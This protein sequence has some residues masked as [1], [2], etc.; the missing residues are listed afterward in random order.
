MSFQRVLHASG[1]LRLRCDG[2][3]GSRLLVQPHRRWGS[4]KVPMGEEGT[5]W[6]TAGVSENQDDRLEA[7]Q[8]SYIN[9]ALEHKATQEVWIP[10]HIWP[11]A[12]PS[13]SMDFVTA[14]SHLRGS[15]YGQLSLAPQPCGAKGQRMLRIVLR[16]ASPGSTNVGANALHNDEHPV[17]LAKLNTFSATCRCSCGCAMTSR[18]SSMQLPPPAGAV[19]TMRV[20]QASTRCRRSLAFPMTWCHHQ[21]CY[22]VILSLRKNGPKS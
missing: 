15:I 18:T 3:G 22:S 7:A 8:R 17:S 16:E 5:I 2:S 11:L 20:W 1:L 13:F 9:R 10:S 14:T 19:P 12:S 6:K 4:R 21:N